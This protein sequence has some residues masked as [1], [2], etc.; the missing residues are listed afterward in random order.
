MVRIRVSGGVFRIILAFVVLSLGA[1]IDTS[2]SPENSAAAATVQPSPVPAPFGH[3]IALP[4]NTIVN[5][6]SIARLGVGAHHACAIR[7]NGTLWCWGDNAFGALGDNSSE[8]LRATPVNESTANTTWTRVDAGGSHTCAMR[9]D[10]STWC[11][12]LNSHGQVGDGS[13]TNRAVAVREQSVAVD[14]VEVSTGDMHACALKGDGSLWCW[15][16]SFSGQLG[17]TTTGADAHSNMPD[18]VTSQSS[19]WTQVTAGGYH[20]CAI[21]TDGSLWCWGNN[22]RGQLGQGN[23]GSDTN[24]AL[25]SRVGADN[26]WMS[27]SAGGWHTC[28]LKTDQSLWCWGSNFY[29]ELGDGTSGSAADRLVP[30]RETTNGTNW[31]LVSAGSHFT[32]ALSATGERFCW[33]LNVDG[34]L[35]NGTA[36]NAVAPARAD[37]DG[38]LWKAVASGGSHSCGVRSDDEVKCWGRNSRGQV[39]AGQAGFQPRYSPAQVA[40]AASWSRVAVG[41]RH[42]CG[43]DFNGRL[44]CWGRNDQGQ[45]GIGA[46]S[47]RALDRPT[48]AQTGI[49]VWTGVAAGYSSGC[50]VAAD[51]TLHCWGS[52]ADGKIGLGN[53][54]LLAAAPT[55]VAGGVTGWTGVDLRARQGCARRSNGTVSCWGL[56]DFQGVATVTP[57]PEPTQA[58][59]WSGIAVGE[60][61]VCAIK[62][63]G[64]LW[65]WGSN[66]Y[67][68]LGNDLAGPDVTSMTPVQEASAATD[69][70]DVV[71]GY[72]FTCA[73]KTG[74]TLWCWG[75]NS[76]GQLGV[77]DAGDG[78]DRTVPTREASAAT[79]WSALSAGNE[80]V[81]A[82]KST[83]TLW[84]W[85]D[86][87]AGQLGTNDTAGRTTPTQEQ[88]ASNLWTR[89][90]A[91]LFSTCAVRNDNTLWCWGDN[92]YGQLGDG[93]GTFTD[94][95]FTGVNLA[96]P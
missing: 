62:T 10:G 55:A 35:G 75:R 79:N 47:M 24:R 37:T 11:W 66:Y 51:Q 17:N 23:Q 92:S 25:P 68:Q 64:T 29:G 36:T 72:G 2:R 33:G 46:A 42:A 52:N 86:N 70:S 6:I 22:L 19:N 54:T 39:G 21:R 18:R 41:D 15:G 44:H 80:H 93:F 85:G 27:V 58:V 32:C 82:L 1:C 71:A 78:T 83:G 3:A 40:A 28:A 69:W 14:W 5:A 90:S 84:C 59:D 81:C 77:G 12:G 61:H 87:L 74:G 38:T 26:D 43:L 76:V 34:Q 53:T 63:S 60:D 20:T 57:V 95:N 94:P 9:A 31:A 45:M 49:P 65:C 88:G 13:N 56:M 89:V 4:P 91:G 50:A 67:G 73:R 30:T 96:V 7:A 8:P 16:S 48:A